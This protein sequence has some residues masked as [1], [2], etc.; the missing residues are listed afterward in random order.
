MISSSSACSRKKKDDNKSRQ[1][2]PDERPVLASGD[3]S[4]AGSIDGEDYGAERNKEERNCWQH[5]FAKRERLE[6]ML[7]TS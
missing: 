3:G 2:Y 6:V 7:L 1:L 5:A 4:S